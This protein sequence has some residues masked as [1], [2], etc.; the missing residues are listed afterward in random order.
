[1]F[2][3]S[4]F[5]DTLLHLGSFNNIDYIIFRNVENFKFQKNSLNLF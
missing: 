3:N 5:V 4:M 1:M 2:D